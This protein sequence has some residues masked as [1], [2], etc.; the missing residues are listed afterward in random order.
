MRLL[1]AI[2]ALLLALL[3][4]QGRSTPKAPR[5]QADGG[6]PVLLGTD[7]PG[8]LRTSPSP[9]DAGVAAERD[10]G[11]D[12]VHR[13]LQALRARVDALELERAQAQETV[14]QL[15]QL[16]DEVQLL[17]QQIADAE[18]QRQAAEQQRESH[19][20]DVQSAVNALYGAQQK[21]MGGN[22]SI[23]AELDQAQ[24]AFTGKAQREVQQA[25]T[26]LQNRDLSAARALLAAAI[27]DAQAGR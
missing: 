25:R 16:N 7:P 8:R 12:E 14:Q 2:P 17:R 18:W 23:E 26:A 10:A 3:L 1:G 22:A 21:I 15:Q 20:A 9:A 19:R 11:G 5:G 24:A 4:G 27:S 13:E 6:R